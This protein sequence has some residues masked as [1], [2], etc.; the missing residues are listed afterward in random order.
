MIV[1]IGNASVRRC[2][3]ESY[4]AKGVSMVSL[5]HPQAVLA[6]EVVEIGRG[7]VIMAGAVIQSDTVIGKGVIINTGA[8]VDHDCQVGDYVHI[9]VGVHLAGNVKVGN[10]TWIGD[11]AVI[12]NNVSICENVMVGAGAVVVA[13]QRVGLMWEFQQ[14]NRVTQIWRGGR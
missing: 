7:T 2:L 12:R 3:L 9:A 11:G 5:I 14:K 6:D 8:S 13:L 1:A 4:E 10:G